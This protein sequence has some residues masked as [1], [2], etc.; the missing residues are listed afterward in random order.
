[1]A[2]HWRLVGTRF[3]HMSMAGVACMIVSAA[4]TWRVSISARG[5]RFLRYRLW[6]DGRRQD[7]MFAALLRLGFGNFRTSRGCGATRPRRC[8]RLSRFAEVEIGIGIT[9]F[10][11]AAA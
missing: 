9:L 2:T 3:S 11:A 10:F 4:L 5:M 6:R 7:G 8:M 1:M